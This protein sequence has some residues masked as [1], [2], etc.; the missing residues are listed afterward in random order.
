[1]PNVADN[2]KEKK[3]VYKEKAFP[4]KKTKS[5]QGHELLRLPNPDPA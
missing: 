4:H 5:G 2:L 1:M 3:W